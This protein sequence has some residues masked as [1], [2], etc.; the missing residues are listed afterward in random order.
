HR[1]RKVFLVHL[2]R[3]RERR[4]QNFDVARKNLDLTAH[5]IWIYRACGPLA[6]TSRHLQYELVAQP[7]RHGESLRRVG[8]AHDLDETF[9][10]T[11]IDEDDTSVIAPPVDPS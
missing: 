2:E 7:I 4:I 6:H 10:V 5:E 3:R 11:H 8:I 1:F 9:A